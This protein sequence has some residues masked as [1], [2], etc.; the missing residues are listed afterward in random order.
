MAAPLTHS[1]CQ[2]Y[3]QLADAQEREGAAKE[4]LVDHPMLPMRRSISTS[5]VVQ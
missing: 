2:Q 5:E 1:L 3:P 4:G